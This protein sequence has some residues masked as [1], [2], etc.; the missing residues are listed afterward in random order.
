MPGLGIGISPIFRWGM[1]SGGAPSVLQPWYDSLSVK[2]SEGL[3]TDL[4][5]L[6]Q[7][8]V[9]AGKWSL[10]DFLSIIA[11]METNEQRLRPLFT[12]S[13]LDITAVGGYTLDVNGFL[14]NGTTG[15]LDFNWNGSLDAVNYALNDS[16]FGGYTGTLGT[17]GRRMM[18]VSSTALASNCSIQ[19]SASINYQ[20]NS[21]TPNASSTGGVNGL[22]SIRRTSSTNIVGKTNTTDGSAVVNSSVAI[23]NFNFFG[24]ALSIDGSPF[25]LSSDTQ[26]MF[27]IGASS[28]QTDDILYTALN[29]FW[30]ARGLTTF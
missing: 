30:A 26:R 6:A 12:S 20:I 17:S 28:L 16:C 19:R 4:K 14:G 8:L 13:G 21:V 27:F 24:S 22:K 10:I 7:T 23:P 18:G 5:I 29:T 9:D 2:P 11:A 25:F 15:Y 3:W 1:D